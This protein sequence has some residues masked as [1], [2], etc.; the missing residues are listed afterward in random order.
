M[1][2]GYRLL[3]AKYI[4]RQAKQLAGQLDGVRAADDIEFVHR[5]R[6]ATRRLRAAL[7][8]FSNC[9][10]PKLVKRWR[11]A[12]RRTT[13]SLGGVR[14]R[15]VQIEFLCGVLAAIDLKVCVPGV[16]AVMIRFEH[17]RRRMQPKVVKSMDR[18]QA[19]GILR[20]MRRKT[21]A[22]LRQSKMTAQ[23]PQT[24]ETIARASRHILRRMGQLLEF[25]DSLA[26]PYDRERHHAMR[27]ALK[28]F[29][30]T[31]EISRPL[32]AGRLDEVIQ[33]IKRVQTLLGDIHDCDVWLEHLDGFISA[34]RGRIIATSGRGDRFQRLRP[35]IEYL[36]ENRRSRRRQ[37]FLELVEYW[38][39]LD[40]RRFWEELA[41]ITGGKPS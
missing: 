40:G 15:D 25:Q 20:E 33:A 18:L 21:T 16:A 7:E 28:R 10:A 13:A 41:S 9:F 38:A 36:Q 37:A 12:I 39:E 3:A 19:K 32:Y 11:K 29:R 14:D 26:N 34:E 6:V 2:S 30:Y 24:P 23:T 22:V 4:R 27:I 8:M 17:E 5:A 31:M 35:G 1:D